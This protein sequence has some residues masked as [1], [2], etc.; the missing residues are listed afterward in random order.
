MARYRIEDGA[1]HVLGGEAAEAVAD[2]DGVGQRV[3]VEGVVERPVHRTH[4]RRQRAQVALRRQRL[5]EL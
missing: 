5:R 3:Q 1:V 2:D 4:L